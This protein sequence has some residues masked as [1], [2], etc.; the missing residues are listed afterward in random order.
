MTV[1]QGPV[2]DA[3]VRVRHA[4]R[5]MRSAWL[6]TAVVMLAAC[7]PREDDERAALVP[8]LC[9]ELCARRV[10][11]VDDGW[12]KSDPEVCTAMCVNEDRY[13]LANICG[14]ASFAVLECMT[15]LTCEELPLAVSALAQG[16]ESVACYAEQVEQR[17]RCSFLIVQ[18]G[19]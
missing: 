9:E 17:E 19:D 8:A 14:E 2:V 6:L 12:A 13:S 4:G 16:D 5:E 3:D 18:D 1:V 11:C 10:T 15:A 7:R